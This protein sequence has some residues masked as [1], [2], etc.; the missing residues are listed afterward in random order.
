MAFQQKKIT[1][2]G[3]GVLKTI[4]LAG[5]AVVVESVG[6][7]SGVDEVPKIIFSDSSNPKQPLYPQA[8]LTGNNAAEFRRF[9]IEGTAESEGDEITLL[10]SDVCMNQSISPETFQARRSGVDSSLSID[11]TDT[12]AQ[13]TELQLI[14]S[15]GDLP[16]KI[17]ISARGADVIYNFLADPTQSAADAAGFGTVLSNEGEQQPVSGINFILGLKFRV[18][19]AADTATLTVHREF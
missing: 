5:F 2:P 7:Y 10:I 16:S 15:A 4:E 13:L 19:T 9:Y 8:V 17:Y 14:N 3:S 1:V 18:K 12:V 11:V 6:T